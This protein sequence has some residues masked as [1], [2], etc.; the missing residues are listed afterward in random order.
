MSLQQDGP[1]HPLRHPGGVG[2][3]RV[4][5]VR[6]STL[7]SSGVDYKP[8]NTFRSLQ[9]ASEEMTPREVYDNRT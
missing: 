8:L 5:A 2:G 7:Q 6:K 3:G 4:Q 9:V 1:R